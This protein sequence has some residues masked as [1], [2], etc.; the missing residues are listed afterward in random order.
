MER[1]SW[2]TPISRSP[3]PSRYPDQRAGI[4][5]DRFLGMGGG[6][7]GGSGTASYGATCIGE[8][9]NRQSGYLCSFSVFGAPDRSGRAAPP[10][11]SRSPVFSVGEQLVA[12]VADVEVPHRQLPD[13]IL[14]RERR[15]ALFHR[16]PLGLVGEVRARRVEDRVVVAAAQLERDLAG[17][18]ARD[19]ALRRLAQHH[20]LRIEP[21]ALVE[22][23]A[24][25]AAV[26]AV[27]LD[28][29]LVVDAGDEPLVAR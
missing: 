5:L 20:R 26:V 2:S 19:P 10:A 27:L 21:A 17:D 22:Q 29:V 13:A 25:P 23:P 6:L 24:E 8:C 1:P 11:D 18:R 9:P 3:S 14:R 15:L 28:R 4:E 7:N 12:R 16:Q